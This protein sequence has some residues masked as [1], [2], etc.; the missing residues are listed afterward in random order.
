MSAFV[1]T[2]QFKANKQQVFDAW[3]HA[4]K[5]VQWWGPKGF[6]TTAK[7]FELKPKGIFHY[8]FQS[9]TVGAMWG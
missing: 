3:A 5:M 7:T 1:I 6:I 9:N 2:R 8:S 4:E